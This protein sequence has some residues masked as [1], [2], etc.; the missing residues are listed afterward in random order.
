MRRSTKKASPAQGLLMLLYRAALP[1]SRPTLDYVAGVIR[2]H[3]RK[4]GSCWR[5]L[6]P[7]QQ[8]LLVLVYLRKGETFAEIAAGFGVSTATAWRYV[9]ETAALPGPVAGT[10]QGAAPGRAGQAGAPG[11]G[12]HPDRGRPARQGPA[13][14]F[15]Q[16]PPARHEPAGHRR[17]RRQAAVGVRAAARRRPRP[18]G[19]PELG[20]HPR[21]GRLRAAR[22]GRQGL[23]RRRDA[24]HPP[25][26]GPGQARVAKERQPRPR[27][28]PRTRRAGKR[29]AQDLAHPPQAP[30]LPLESRP[31]RQG[32][33]R[34]ANPR[35]PRMKKAQSCVRF[36]LFPK[37]I[38]SRGCVRSRAWICVFSSTDSTIA[39]SGGSRYSATISATFT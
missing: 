21:A 37:A 33:P 12:R 2:R 26:Q 24:R 6:S 1:L 7:G 20:H 14:L 8:A 18:E 29:P 30:L 15:R 16:A 10:P 9:N 27:P 3:R 17:A 39:P 19:S 38:G 22:P 25:V 5:K 31:A 32:R 23:S 36:S 4:T 11:A 35:G 13:V 28:A 34:P